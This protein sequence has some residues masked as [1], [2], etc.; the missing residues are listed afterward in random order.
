MSNLTLWG[1]SVGIGVPH[2]VRRSR[3]LLPSASSRRFSRDLQAISLS[4]QMRQIP[5]EGEL[6]ARAEM[7]G[8]LS[9]MTFSCCCVVEANDLGDCEPSLP[10]GAVW[11]VRKLDSGV[12]EGEL[13]F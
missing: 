8:T 12:E 3:S 11:A 1:W 5:A 6:A 9:S 7:S 10:E 2:W 13:V 4:T